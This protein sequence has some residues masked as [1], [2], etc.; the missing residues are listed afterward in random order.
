[1]E[2][3]NAGPVDG[4]CEQEEMNHVEECN[5]PQK[6]KFK[7]RAIAI[8]A[9]LLVVVWGISYGLGINSTGNYAGSNNTA[10]GL[11]D[12]KVNLASGLATSVQTGGQN[13]VTEIVNKIGA[14]VVTIETE[15]YQTTQSN[16]YYFYGGM[17]GPTTR[18]QTVQGLGSGFIITSDGYL[19]T[20]YH[21]V[22]G[23]N[24]IKVKL[25]GSDQRY[26]AAVVGYDSDQ[27]LAVLQIDA[28]KNHPVVT[29]GNSDS[30]S[31][32]DWAIAIG[33]PYGLDH[34]VTLGVISAKER[35]MTIEDKN[36]KS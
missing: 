20:N 25:L 35:P 5:K 34:T 1:M 15:T 31:T 7:A 23:V 32:G 26:N 27:D 18:Q 9:F 29:L 2:P 12:Q 8:A 21:V 14:A 4:Q 13:S 28:G 3:F 22:E 19:L 33:N 11:L 10:A 6:G 16:R 30:T 36:Y 17:F 24:S